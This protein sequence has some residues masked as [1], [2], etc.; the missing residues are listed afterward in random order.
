[1]ELTY[2]IYAKLSLYHRTY[3]CGKFHFILVR[4]FLKWSKGDWEVE[5]GAST[6]DNGLGVQSAEKSAGRY[7]KQR[8]KKKINTQLQTT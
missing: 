1:M 5:A 4:Y 7:P 3:I 6:E 8:N 2:R